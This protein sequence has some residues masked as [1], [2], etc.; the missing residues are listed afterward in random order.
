M[1]AD[2]FWYEMSAQFSKKNSSS[3]W[4]NVPSDKFEE[5]SASQTSPVVNT[6]SV[7]K[8]AVFQDLANNFENP[9]WLFLRT[10]LA[11]EKN[12]FVQINKKL[13]ICLIRSLQTYKSLDTV[14]NSQ[15]VVRHRLEFLNSLKSC[16][17][18]P[19]LLSVELEHW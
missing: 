11:S 8:A 14:A 12:C 16:G 9:S 2:L 13:L 15:E 17:L 1:I 7:L 10:G 18:Q 4:R 3:R 6:L 19:H 5:I